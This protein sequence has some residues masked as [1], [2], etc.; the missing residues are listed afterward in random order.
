MK[1][2]IVENTRLSSSKER[3]PA[4]LKAGILAC[5]VFYEYE[6]VHLFARLHIRTRRH[7]WRPMCTLDADRVRRPEKNAV[8]R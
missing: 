7:S 3:K 6:S 4:N 2:L 8:K 5:A 1:L